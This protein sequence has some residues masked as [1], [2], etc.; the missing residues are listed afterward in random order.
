M[1]RVVRKFISSFLIIVLLL[2]SVH[3]GT[4]TLPSERP[5]L[6]GFSNSPHEISSEGRV[7]AHK[8][9][10]QNSDLLLEDFAEGLPWEESLHD[11]PYPPEV[12]TSLRIRKRKLKGKKLFIH[13]SPFNINRTGPVKYWPKV[14][15]KALQEK[16]KKKDFADQDL[17]LAYLKFCRQLIGRF[18]PE[19]FA[20]AV[21]V[22]LFA[23]Q[24][25]TEWNNFVQFAG[26]T[27]SQ[28]K[29]E[30]PKLP[31]F[32][33]INAGSFWKDPKEQEQRIR[34]IL[35]YTDFI[36]VS[37]FPELS[38]F[39]NVSKLPKDFFS[40]LAMME[41]SKPFAIAETGY[42]QPL[43]GSKNRTLQKEYLEFVLRQSHDL[44]ARFVVWFHY[45][46]FNKIADK[47]AGSL[48]SSQDSIELLDSRKDYGLVDDAGNSKNSY[49][50]WK[51]WFQLPFLDSNSGPV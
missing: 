11:R 2:L 22:N 13:V 5:F 38:G 4:N 45:R 15:E 28:L 7:Q 23:A 50:V 30:H 19:F 27:Y 1:K 51:K 6:M 12:Q 9:L 31:I 25:P 42:P 35:P 44:H 16:W 47:A 49:A 46:D 26:E 29:K 17:K 48:K 3:C 18:D 10:E 14:T 21:D 8:F 37:A 40:R 33:N 24:R 36:A 41:T 43:H 20:Y 39:T 32:L 34:E